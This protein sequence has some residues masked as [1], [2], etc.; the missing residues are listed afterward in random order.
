MLRSDVCDYS[1]A[2][3]VARERIT[4]VGDNDAKIIKS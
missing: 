3:I 4:V 2:Y 1:D